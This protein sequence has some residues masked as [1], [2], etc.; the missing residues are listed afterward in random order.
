M[1]RI[2]Q[3]KDGQLTST[4]GK[5]ILM[6]VILV[7]SFFFLKDYLLERGGGAVG[8]Q[9]DK[10]ADADGDGVPNFNDECC[11][12][13]CSPSRPEFGNKPV[14]LAGDLRGCIKD[15]QGPTRDCQAVACNPPPAAGPAVAGAPSPR[16]IG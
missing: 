11:P 2:L 6:V 5:I 4:M 15:A 3:N 14:E 10:P 16:P 8:K 13:A 7:I 9:V 1:R 12:A